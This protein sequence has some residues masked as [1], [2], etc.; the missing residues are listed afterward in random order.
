M[1]FLNF[2]TLR[3]LWGHYRLPDG[4]QVKAR[5]AVTYIHRAEDGEDVSIDF[6]TGVS[7][8]A[9]EEHRGDPDSNPDDIEVLE[10]YDEFERLT[11]PRC[12]YLVEDKDLLILKAYPA[13]MIR[14][15]QFHD[16]GQ[17]VIEVRHKLE[18]DTV[19]GAAAPSKVPE[20][21]PAD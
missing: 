8:S 18:V 14:Y 13:R 4:I 15:N 21:T 5:P 2:E 3:E 6:T 7:I 9:P 12:F 20:A 19:K 16:N 10:E 1:E 17:P 11:V